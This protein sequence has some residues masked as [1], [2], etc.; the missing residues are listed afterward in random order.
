MNF[1]F[2]GLN[3][4]KGVQVYF[5]GWSSF[6]F[7]FVLF[8]FVLFFF[9]FFLNSQKTHINLKLKFFKVILKKKKFQV[10]YRTTSAASGGEPEKQ[11]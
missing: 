2:N 4:I 8:C 9:F 5:L 1:I 10:G 6:L 7:C 11:R 3:F